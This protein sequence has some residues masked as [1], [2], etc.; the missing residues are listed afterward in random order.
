MVICLGSLT[1][2]ALQPLLLVMLTEQG[3]S[4]RT[5]PR[6]TKGG[7]WDIIQRGLTL[8]VWALSTDAWKGL[9]RLSLHFIQDHETTMPTAHQGNM[10]RVSTA[11]C[12]PSLVNPTSLAGPRRPGSPSHSQ[13]AHHY[14]KC[15]QL[16]LAKDIFGPLHFIHLKFC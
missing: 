16:F 12:Q 13:Q 7:T 6:C 5:R 2:S 10:R 1:P 8:R 4:C 15:Q 11:A 14:W 9:L 3:Q